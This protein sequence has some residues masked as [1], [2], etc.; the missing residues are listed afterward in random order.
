MLKVVGTNIYVRQKM[1]NENVLM[2]FFV[3]DN[4][5]NIAKNLIDPKIEGNGKC[6]GM[7]VVIGEFFFPP[8]DGSSPINY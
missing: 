8:K 4:F 3:C 7:L 1:G 2:V 5:V 6:S